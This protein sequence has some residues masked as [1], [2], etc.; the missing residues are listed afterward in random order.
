[1]IPLRDT[2]PCRNYPVV[3]GLLIAA[4][5]V[6]YIA[7]TGYG[8]ELQRFFYFY[9]LVPARYTVP[10]I[11]AYFTTGQQ[12]FALFSFMF[13]HGGF[14]HLLGNLWM[15]YIFGDNIEDRLGPF[16]YLAFYLLC[17]LASGL[18]HIALNLSEQ[19][20]VIGASGAIAG[21]MGAY[22]I[23]YPQAK[24]LTFIPVLFIPYFIELPAFIFLGLWLVMQFLNAATASG[25]AG[26]IAWWAHIG[27]FASGIILLKLMS[28]IP[29]GRL[30]GYVRRMTAK[31]TTERLQVIRPAGSSRDANLYGVL[32]VTPYEARTGTRKLVNIPSGMRK[33]LFRVTIP[34]GVTAG[35]VLRLRGL[36][37]SAQDG[38]RGDLM[39]KISMQT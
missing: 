6:V 12:L 30:S 15:L 26:G 14:F 24:I 4:N 35:T 13:L 23:L 21:V 11:A 18:S 34:P 31:K 37:R 3:N 27:G 25:A 19:V 17:G 36:G 7:Q 39:L 33:R 8:P 2:T 29:G 1:M 10:E 38:S 5:V 16:R 32:A 20:P 22:F 9:G 28:V